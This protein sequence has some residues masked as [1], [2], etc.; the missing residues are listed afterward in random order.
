MKAKKQKI[1]KLIHNKTI[2]EQSKFIIDNFMTK[3]LFF[4][5]MDNLNKLID[6]LPTKKEFF[7]KIDEVIKAIRDTRINI[8]H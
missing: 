3:D 4:K 1:S 6:K 8:A 7:D 5:E 2:D